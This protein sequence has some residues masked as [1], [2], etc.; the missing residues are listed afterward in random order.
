LGGEPAQDAGQKVSQT[1]GGAGRKETANLR[2]SALI[3][4]KSEN[5][6]GLNCERREICDIDARP[7]PGLVP[8]EKEEYCLISWEATDG[9]GR[10]WREILNRIEHRERKEKV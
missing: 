9:K 8:Q 7:Q 2:S 3:I 10:I 4:W 1:G 5:G 6:K